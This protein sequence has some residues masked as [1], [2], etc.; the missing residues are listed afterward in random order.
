AL[1]RV[2]EQVKITDQPLETISGE[3]DLVIAN[4][5][6]EENVRLAAQLVARLSGQGCLI[7]SGILKE[8]ET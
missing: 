4:I 6:A 3:F 8:K 7:L 1:N 2:T 5:M